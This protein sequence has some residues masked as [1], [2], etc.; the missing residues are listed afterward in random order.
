MLEFHKISSK[1]TL[2]KKG[3][4]LTL[5]KKFWAILLYWLAIFFFGPKLFEKQHDF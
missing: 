3:D 1:S 2:G 4:Y 5:E